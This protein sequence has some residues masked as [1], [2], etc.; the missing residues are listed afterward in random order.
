ML[1]SHFP[2]PPSQGG[3]ALRTF[4]LMKYLGERHDLTLVTQRS[5]NITD[6]QVEAMKEWVQ[7]VVV[8]P[9]VQLD[10]IQT[11]LLKK[12]KRLQS[13]LKQGIPPGVPSCYSPA[14]EAWV[15]EAVESGQFDV[16]TSED[17]I[18]EIYV[19]PEWRGRLRTVV[20]V[21]R[22]IYGIWKQ[23]LETPD[24][25]VLRD[26]LSLPL[27]RRYEERYCAKFSQVVATT[28]EDGRQL[29]ALNPETRIVVIP[30]GV[31][32]TL[33]PKRKQDRGGNKL[34]FVGM[35]DNPVNI[36][37]VSF[38]SREIFPEI[39]QRYPETSLEIV[40]ANPTTEVKMLG[41]IPGVTVIGDVLN[42]VDY[43]HDATV[44][45][46][47]LQ[48]GLGI[49]NK[50]L[51]AMAVGIPLVASDRALQGITVD[52]ADIPL[53]A[54][55]ANKLEEYIYAIGRLFA[56][57]KLREKLSKQARSHIENDY[58]WAKAGALYEKA[59]TS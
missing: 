13:Y 52:G 51:E 27:L 14:M 12:A 56:E 44:C 45:V 34:I 38:L 53:R 20:N 17:S 47:P 50:S 8:F 7:E 48:K 21:H 2:Y 46:I 33:F 55:R 4:N 30:N 26:Q 57:P 15:D 49:Q 35:L 10:P 19:R 42:V 39:C 40:G 23:R 5:G 31:D 37:A 16:I 59:L 28:K 9:Q 22:S 25:K 24:Q 11:G 54:M 41:E 1:S 58:T 6:D 18:N 29:K 36:K 43:L 32:L 3:T